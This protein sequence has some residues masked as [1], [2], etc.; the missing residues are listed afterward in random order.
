MSIQ[1]Y[2]A[3]NFHDPGEGHTG[4]YAQ[5]LEISRYWD[6]PQ[7]IHPVIHKS[8]RQFEFTG[9]ACSLDKDGDVPHTQ[10]ECFGPRFPIA[11]SAQ[12]APSLA[13]SRM[14]VLALGTALGSS[15]N[16]DRKVR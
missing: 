5:T 7:S 16:S 15:Q 12:K 2:A 11:L 1:P 9:I 3:T 14:T 13:I 4:L 10:P 8:P 6:C